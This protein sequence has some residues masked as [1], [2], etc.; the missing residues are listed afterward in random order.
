MKYVKIALEFLEII[1]LVLIAYVGIALV[2]I[3]H[4]YGHDW[5]MRIG[6][7]IKFVSLIRLGWVIRKEHEQK[8][9]G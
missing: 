9:N 7:L 4:E 1:A 2:D 6:I 3:G 8:S 5:T